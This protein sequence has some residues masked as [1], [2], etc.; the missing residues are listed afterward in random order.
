[1][2]NRGQQPSFA[3]EFVVVKVLGCGVRTRHR[4]QRGSA[5]ERFEREIVDTVEALDACDRAPISTG[6]SNVPF[7][8]F[9]LELDKPD[10]AA[11]RF[12]F[13]RSGSATHAMS[14]SPSPPNASS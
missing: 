6:R 7:A 5:M 8:E 11:P 1:M 10:H 4:L 3:Y 14:R 2:V 12:R 9:I 13:F